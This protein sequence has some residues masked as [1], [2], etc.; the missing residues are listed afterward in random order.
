MATDSEGNLYLAGAAAS[1][2][3]PGLNGLP[4]GCRPNYLY[5][6]PFLTRLS[7]DGAS[8]TATQLAFDSATPLLGAVFDGQGKAVLA[9]GDSLWTVD[10][11]AP[12]LPFSCMV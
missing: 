3:F 6:V 11:F 8:L 4:D 2:D 5:P 7:A 1:P 9:V 10:L 12:T